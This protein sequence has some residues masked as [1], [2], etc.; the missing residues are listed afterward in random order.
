MRQWPPRPIALGR[1]TG[2]RAHGPD[3]LLVLERL[4]QAQHARDLALVDLDL[5][6]GPHRQVGNLDL[7]GALLERRAHGREVA[8]RGD[9]LPYVLVANEVL[10]ARIDRDDQFVLVVALDVDEHDALLLEVPGDRARLAKAPAAAR[11]DVAHLGARAVAVVGE[12]LHEHG[13]AAGCVALI[14]RGLPR[15]RVG[16]VARAL[17]DRP[18]DVVL[19]HARVA[20]LLDR[21]REGR[22]A[23]RIGPAVARGDLDCTRELREELPALGVRGALL[24]LDRGPFRVAGHALESRRGRARRRRVWNAPRAVR[25]TP[26]TGRK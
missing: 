16:V 20:C 5:R 7:D 2:A 14:H 6:L 15:R 10:R 4:E 9:D 21:G 12:R 13:D 26:R 19:R 1:L 17:G 8:R 23:G 3:V 11:E 18:L 25:T 22:V 24:V